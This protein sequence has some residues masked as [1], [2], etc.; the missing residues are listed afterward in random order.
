MKRK[1]TQES[2]NRSRQRT[3]LDEREQ[4]SE[5]ESEPEQEP[6]KQ[7][8]QES[9]QELEE[10]EF[11][12]SISESDN[13]SPPPESSQNKLAEDE[14]DNHS[15]QHSTER[16]TAQRPVNSQLSAR[17][18]KATWPLMSQAGRNEIMRIIASEVFPTLNSIHGERSKQEFQ[19]TVLKNLLDRLDRKLLKVP[20]PPSTRKSHYEWE[21]LNGQNTRLE[22]TLAPMLEQNTHLE[23]EILREMKLL[24]KDKMYLKTL[25]TNSKSQIQVMKQLGK[26]A[27]NIYRVN[28]DAGTQTLGSLADTKDDVNL[29]TPYD[30]KYDPQVLQDENEELGHAFSSKRTK[31]PRT[32][33]KLTPDDPLI[34][35]L[36]DLSRHL[37]KIKASTAPLN[38]LLQ[39][40]GKLE[41]EM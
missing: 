40:C 22:S 29:R 15:D 16:V 23:R 8:E 1:N 24:E 9:E 5:L 32:E 11:D 25:E 12:V 17:R 31:L 37:T 10:K 2:R 19:V 30:L 34:P 7:V 4:E 27:Q 33:Y 39:E 26:K 18:I 20:V 38:A 21:T 14:I 13:Y 3:R 41:Q 35:V 28:A 6:D 36:R